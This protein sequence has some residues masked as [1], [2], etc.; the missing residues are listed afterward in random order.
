MLLL[1][2][3]EHPL[4]VFVVMVMLSF[5]S[6]FLTRETQETDVWNANKNA[7]C[8]L[9]NSTETLALL[10]QNLACYMKSQWTQFNFCQQSG[11]TPTMDF[12]YALASDSGKSICAS[13]KHS[14]C[15]T[16]SPPLL[17]ASALKVHFIH[18][19]NE[20]I[21]ELRPIVWVAQGEAL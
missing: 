11:C 4:I 16:P 2:T 18:I 20:V 8:F 15:P 6:I 9:S 1:L 7:F 3:S 13:W 5:C 17:S 19:E 12:F 14:V 21:S 10:T